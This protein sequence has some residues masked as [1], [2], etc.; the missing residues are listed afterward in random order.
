MAVRSVVLPDG[1]SRPV[2]GRTDS[3]GDCGHSS[4]SRN[5]VVDSSVGLV[6]TASEPKQALKHVWPSNSSFTL[7]DRIIF[8]PISAS[9]LSSSWSPFSSASLG[10]PPPLPVDGCSVAYTFS[11]TNLPSYSSSATVQHLPIA[12]CPSIS[13]FQPRDPAIPAMDPYSVAARRQS[14][15]T[16]SP[17][18]D[19]AS[20]PRMQASRVCSTTVDPHM[21]ISPESIAP[22]NLVLGI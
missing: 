15:P 8:D 3:R 12:T 4:S 20:H 10:S 2:D 16:D 7:L 22:Q 18:G 1:Q 11:L 14:G 5:S 13:A 9:S 19:T 17:P 6:V 21:W